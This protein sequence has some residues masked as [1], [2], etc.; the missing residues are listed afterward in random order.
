MKHV[1]SIGL[2]LG[3]LLF[4][5]M[6]M[7]QDFAKAKQ[8]G[9]V[10]FYTSWGPSDADYVIKGFEKKYPFLKVDPVRSSSEKTLNRLL[11]RTASQ[12]VSRRR[13]GDQRDSVGNFEREKA[14]S[15]ATSHG[16][17]ELS[18][19]MEDPDGFG[20]G[21]HQTIYV[22][23][24]NSKLVPAD[25]VPKDIRGS[26]ESSVERTAGLGSGRVLSRSALC[27]ESQ[28]KNKKDWR[29]GSGWRNNKSISG[30]DIR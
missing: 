24:Y 3:L 25:A 13:R 9:R 12:L 27:N 28:G 14:L 5:A 10:V 29:S 18:G 16:R 6:G 19:G 26:T 23:G 21:L 4:S 22:I 2:A 7:A 17:R 1:G 8:E 30:K 11:D 20:V 15:I